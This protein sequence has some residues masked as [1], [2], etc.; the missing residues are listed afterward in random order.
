MADAPP[1]PHSAIALYVLALLLVIIGLTTLVHG[2]LIDTALLT[3]LLRLGALFI[4]ALGAMFLGHAK[5]PN[6]PFPDT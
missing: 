3:G 6:H 2:F 1:V 5:N 4:V